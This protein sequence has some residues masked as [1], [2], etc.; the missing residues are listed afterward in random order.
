MIAPDSGA[1]TLLYEYTFNSP[2]AL[3]GWSEKIFRGK[4]FYEVALD[5][6]AG[7]VMK[8][9]S[10]GTSSGLY[11][12]VK[13][14]IH[15]GPILEWEWKVTRFPQY[16]K[17]L[18]LEDVHNNDYAVR[19]YAIFEGRTLFSSDVI[20]YVWDNRVSSGT[21]SNSPL[22]E[23]VKI[24]VVRGNSDNPSDQW[25]QEK[26]NLAKDYEMLFGEFPRKNLTAI[27]IMSDSDDTQSSTEAYLKHISIRIPLVEKGD[28]S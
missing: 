8:V 15:K 2:Y 13:V 7:F 14:P 3:R 12:K 23:R 19:I 18:P 22:S 20:E 5:Q 26:R 9:Q 1:Y 16:N 6:K 25:H 28:L 11:R 17:Q 10:Q 27:A 4:T 21:Y 24:F